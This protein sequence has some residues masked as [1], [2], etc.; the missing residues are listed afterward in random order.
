MGRL[1]KASLFLFCLLCYVITMNNYK[2]NGFT[3]VELAIVLVVIGMLVAF[4]G[5]M[6]APLTTFVKVRE[7]RDMQ[8]SAV[9]S[10][11]SWAS[12]NNTIPNETTFMTV[13]KSP[14]DAWGQNLIYLYDSN[15][16]SAT[17]T[18]DTICGRRSTDL[19]L[20]TNYSNSI[21]F[22]VISRADNP[23]FKSTLNGTLNSNPINSVITTSG[24]ATGTITATGTNSD[25][26]RWVT[27]DE[28]RSKIG[29]LGAPLKIVNNELPFGSYSSNYSASII[30]DGGSGSG[31]YQWRI[32]KGSFPAGINAT[33][34]PFQNL[35]TTDWT[36]ASTMIIDGYPKLPGSYYFSVFVR[37]NI[38]NTS[39]KAFVLTVN[40]R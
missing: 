37:D 36:P 24:A 15:L 22:A 35:S 26:V 33:A 27:L 5:S 38:G 23:A 32:K 9:Q 4:G 16:H 25:L 7:T 34:L 21:A 17:P 14:L 31:D 10:V 29:C 12:S 2:K 39:S 40:P 28:L 13:A 8:D 1:V 3:L 11:I 6:I 20:F 19:K 18:K 30:A